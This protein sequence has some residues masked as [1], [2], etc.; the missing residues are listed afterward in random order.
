MTAQQRMNDAFKKFKDYFDGRGLKYGT[1]KSPSGN[2]VIEIG[3]KGKDLS[4]NF[5][6]TFD[7]KNEAIVLYSPMPFNFDEEKMVEGALVCSMLTDRFREGSFDFNVTQ[8]SITF[9]L[10][11]VVMGMTV[12]SELCAHMFEL[13]V[14]TVDLYNDKLFMVAKGML[15]PQEFY[16]KISG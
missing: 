9:R 15:T 5:K 2:D 10:V 11:N 16:D 13:A 4:M 14:H 3:G 7:V 6:I 1:E 12:S 8:G